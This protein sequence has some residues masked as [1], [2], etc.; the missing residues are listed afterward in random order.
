MGA[1]VRSSL[2]AGFDICLGG[3]WGTGVG[4]LLFLDR[5]YLDS[6]TSVDVKRQGIKGQT[7]QPFST[8]V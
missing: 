7:G 4:Y 8:H 2:W 6:F 5:F 3:G 1:A